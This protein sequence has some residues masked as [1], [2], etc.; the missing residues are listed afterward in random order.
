MAAEGGFHS[1]TM[2]TLRFLL[3]NVD[4]ISISKVEMFI[5]WA[6]GEPGSNFLNANQIVRDNI[7]HP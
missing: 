4:N 5:R 6:S 2:E 3:D 7:W 1:A